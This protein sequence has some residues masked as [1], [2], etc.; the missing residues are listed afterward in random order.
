MAMF[1]G[2][3]RYSFAIFNK[4]ANQCGKPFRSPSVSPSAAEA[5]SIGGTHKKY[6][7]IDI[8]GLPII[9]LLI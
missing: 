4:K 7:A 2:I 5:A 6:P 9:I 1:T 3:Y 8:A